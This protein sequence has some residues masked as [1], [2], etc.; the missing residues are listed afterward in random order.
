MESK[1]NEVIYNLRKKKHITQ[2]ML[3]EA[4]GV[5]RQAVQKWES[6]AA[7]PELSKLMELSKYFSVSLD[8]LVLNKNDN[9]EQN[10]YKEL[11]PLYEN[12]DVWENYSDYMS[13]EYNQCC[14][15]G[16][17]ISMYKDLFKIV[18]TLPHGEIK[19]DLADVVYKVVMN[20]KV[21]DNYK[22]YE[23]SNLEEIKLYRKERKIENTNPDNLEN[24]IHGAW[25]GRICGCMLGK[26]LEGV[27]RRDFEA[28]LKDIGN[29]PLN[30][31][32]EM[33]DLTDEIKEKY[34]FGF[35]NTQAYADIINGMPV[36]DDTNYTVLAQVIIDKYGKDFTSVD[37]SKIWL[38]YQT[39]NAYCTAE[40][41]AY[42]NF[43]MGYQPPVSALYKNPYR[44][45][46]GAQIRGDYWGYINPGNPEAA[47]DMAFRD[48]SIS[49]VKNGIYGEMFASAMIAAAAVTSNIEEIIYSGLGQIPYT[50]RLYEAVE[51]IVE[52]HREGK[53]REEV[54]DYIHSRYDEFTEHGWCHTISNAMVVA[55]A[56]LYGNGDFEKSICY[57]VEAAFDTDCN[58]ATVGS[59]VGMICGIDNV[60]EKWS[61]PFDDTLNTSIFG[62]G[63]VKISDRVKLTMK[64]INE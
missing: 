4:I 22:Y 61:A 57:A 45:W 7:V 38:G 33:A 41:V 37:V 25:M 60:P 23:P 18:D 8:E 32:L 29:Y 27:K 3:A 63:T 15:E 43:V 59:V 24:K 55:Y 34:K 62:V 39:K 21:K 12:M 20:A 1:L 17:D 19:N 13:T 28:F 51:E 30:R 36:D 31:Y 49:H 26:P 64:H 46:I 47:A 42:R 56:L 14:E 53:T 48:A 52:M 6:G 54:V 10:Y 44:E 40:R 50:S 11:K 9:R 16:L 35:F 5:S 2:E 58:G